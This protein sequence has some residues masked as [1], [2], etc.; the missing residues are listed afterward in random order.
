MSDF[1]G[2]NKEKI[3]DFARLEAADYSRDVI[4]KWLGVAKST[5]TRWEYDRN[6]MKTLYD[7]GGSLSKIRCMFELFAARVAIG[8]TDPHDLI[9][10]L[11]ETNKNGRGDGSFAQWKDEP[12]SNKREEDAAQAAQAE[13]LWLERLCQ[14]KNNPQFTKRE[15][16]YLSAPKKAAEKEQLWMQRLLDVLASEEKKGFS[17]ERCAFELYAVWRAQGQAENEGRKE[18]I[19]LLGGA[20]SERFIET[21]QQEL[22]ARLQ[23]YKSWDDLQKSEA[24]QLWQDRI[25]SPE[26]PS[27]AK[28]DPEIVEIKVR[29]AQIH[30]FEALQ[31][32]KKIEAFCVFIEKEEK[33]IPEDILS[34]INAIRPDI[35]KAA[36]RCDIRTDQLIDILRKSAK[37]FVEIEAEI[38]SILAKLKTRFPDAAVEP[39]KPLLEAIEDLNRLKQLTL[40]ASSVESFQT[41]QERLNA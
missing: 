8:K 29:Y 7:V 36:E 27:L 32:V 23:L 12:Q 34:R 13:K 19:A 40:E 2:N 22:Q 1:R 14:W 20:E 11:S 39:L 18:I 9:A 4:A 6:F 37:H 25:E 26:K 21:K 33:D 31:T 17:K 35:N 38:E 15:E 5:L 3:P 24:E 41:F 10:L 28:N 16:E 30:L